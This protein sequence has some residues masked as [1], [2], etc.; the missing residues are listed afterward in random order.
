LKPGEGATE[1]PEELGIPPAPVD[2]TDEQAVEVPR[3]VTPS[4]MPKEKVHA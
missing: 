1:T 3:T 2:E 4:R